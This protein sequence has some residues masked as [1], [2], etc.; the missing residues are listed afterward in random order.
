ML[1]IRFEGAGIDEILAENKETDVV[2]VYTIS[3]TQLRATNDVQGLPAGLYIVGG[4][5]VVVK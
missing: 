1:D 2:G 4:V 5:K 3:G